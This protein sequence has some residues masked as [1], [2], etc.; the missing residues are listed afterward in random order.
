M[1][2]F[3]WIRTGMIDA[4]EAIQDEERFDELFGKIVE[5]GNQPNAAA[6]RFATLDGIAS[7]ATRDTE[8]H[9]GEIDHV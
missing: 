4:L 2:A 6:N 5:S 8:T 3:N 7:S 9:E 1:S